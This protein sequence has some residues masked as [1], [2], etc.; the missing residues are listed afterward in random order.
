VANHVCSHYKHF[1]LNTNAILTE[2]YINGYIKNYK[3]IINAVR[4]TNIKVANYNKWATDFSYRNLLAKDLN[5]DNKVDNVDFVPGLGG[6]SSFTKK[7]ETANREEY[8]ERYKKI[9][10]PKFFAEEICKDQE[11][12]NFNKQT[13]GINI[14]ELLGV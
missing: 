12:Y 7:E 2:K 6:G 14:D 9:K 11:I 3:K 10:L 8:N 13:F 5:I 4:T 1:I